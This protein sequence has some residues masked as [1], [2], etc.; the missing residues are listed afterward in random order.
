MS[1][2]PVALTTQQRDEQSGSVDIGGHH[3]WAV[4][5]CRQHGDAHLSGEF[6]T[7]NTG[8]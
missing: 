4:L 8:S 3:Y 6:L 7:T 1:D 2:P 5:C